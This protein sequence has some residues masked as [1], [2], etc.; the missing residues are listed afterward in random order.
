MYR[1]GLAPSGI[2]WLGC[3]DDLDLLEGPAPDLC[4]LCFWAGDAP[5]RLWVSTVGVSFC[6][7]IVLLAP[8]TCQSYVITANH[9]DQIIMKKINNGV[10]IDSLPGPGKNEA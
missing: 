10:R 7:P 4:G 3:T 5:L 2:S 6:L 8:S 9:I 1:G